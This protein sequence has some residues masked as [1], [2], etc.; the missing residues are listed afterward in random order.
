MGVLVFFATVFAYDLAKTI[1]ANTM[2]WS[3]YFKDILS[4]IEACLFDG[5]VGWLFLL[6]P[7]TYGAVIGVI[8]VLI[9][10]AA[11]TPGFLKSVTVKKVDV[12]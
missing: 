7:G 8:D 4:T 10:N 9:I 12:V 11:W 2:S 5:I 6:V 1:A 3:K